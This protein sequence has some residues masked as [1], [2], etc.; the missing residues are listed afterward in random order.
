MGSL[1]ASRYS[2]RYILPVVYGLIM[3]ALFGKTILVD[4]IEMIVA[5]LGTC[6]L[7]VFAWFVGQKKYWQ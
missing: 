6:L 5:T 3:G 1:L 7:C 4:S 2:K